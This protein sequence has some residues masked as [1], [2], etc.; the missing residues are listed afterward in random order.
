MK[1]HYLIVILL[2]GAAATIVNA[3]H[4]KPE[5]DDGLANL[6]H[7]PFQINKQW[8]GQDYQLDQS[9]YDILETN[10]IIHRSYTK[11]NKEHVFLSVVHYSDT[12]VDFHAPEACL[13]AKGLKA[14]KTNRKIVLQVDNLEINFNVAKLITENN[15]YK[16]LTY[17]FYKSG[18]F[19]GSNYILLRFE[20]AANKLSRGDTRGS[21]IRVS[22][23]FT[24]DN[25]AVAETL[26][27]GFL[28]DI[29]PYIQQTL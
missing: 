23:I 28:E 8:N 13:G 9:V 6:Q 10:S 24:Q 17:Y 21:L 26:L 11:N 16:T 19:V 7:F 12:K 3:L 29:F 27:I 1:L 25:E 18:N 22:T 20:I 5:H 2:L 15:A 4:Y 14:S